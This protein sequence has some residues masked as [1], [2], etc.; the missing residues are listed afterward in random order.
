MRKS[1]REERKRTDEEERER[2]IAEQRRVKMSLIVNI[3][4]KLL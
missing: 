4:L 3:V 2:I 1:K